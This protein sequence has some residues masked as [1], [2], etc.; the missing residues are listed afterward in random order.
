M[1]IGKKANASHLTKNGNTPL[2]IAL[3][4]KKDLPLTTL[5]LSTNPDV[6]VLCGDK[7]KLT[8]L[9]VACTMEGPFVRL[10]LE[11]GANP[12]QTI[13]N[14]LGGESPLS[15]AGKMNFH[16]TVDLLI[17]AGA[18]VNLPIDAEG[19]TALTRLFIKRSSNL[20]P[21]SRIHMVKH[22]IA[23]GADIRQKFVDG[24]HKGMDALAF[25]R[26]QGVE[27][28]ILRILEEKEAELKTANLRGQAL[29]TIKAG[30][31]ANGKLVPK[32]RRT[33]RHNRKQTMRRLRRTRK[34]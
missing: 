1:L 26:V 29:G 15:V 25:A 10:F 23:K 9:T 24:P 18:S 30:L 32:E 12:N 2:L 16:G 19:L 5:L 28:G 13:L 31:V 8:Y 27:P 33:R 17:K 3:Y 34:W 11:K 4:T 20:M 22:L 6:N 14:P 21:H 7:I